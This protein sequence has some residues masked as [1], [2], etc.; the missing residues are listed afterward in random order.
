MD[1]VTHH[2]YE[3]FYDR[4]L[5][6]Y[7]GTGGILEI[8]Y[9]SG[10]SIPFWQ[11]LFP[12]AELFVVD[13]DAELV[14]PRYRVWAYDQSVLE[15]LVD[16]RERVR[17]ADIG[18]I[19]DDGSH[20]PEHQLLTLNVLFEILRPGGTY[21]IEDIECS[22]WRFG[23]I[24]GYPTRYGMR[25]RRALT[26]KLTPIVHWINREFLSSRQRSHLER[27]LANSG[28]ASNVLRDVSSIEFGHNCIA[29]H[30]SR[31]AYDDLA[32]REYRFARHVEQPLRGVIGA[33][34]P[35][36]MRSALRPLRRLGR[37]R[38]SS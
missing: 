20:I 5:S 19:V 37:R 29:I 38:R 34:L 14:G 17:D 31:T 4:F 27:E 13:R 11:E 2:A 7:D 21:V 24:Y 33:H 6:A 30:K 23:A 32:D 12:H 8:G 9:G 16:L 36:W 18:V 1:K 26:N 22:Y 25:S 35:A 28:I 15:D 10:A 3:R